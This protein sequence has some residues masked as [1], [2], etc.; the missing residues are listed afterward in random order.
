MRYKRRFWTKWADKAFLP[1]SDS[2]QCL[3]KLTWGVTNGKDV[4]DQS[5]RSSPERTL[6][7]TYTIFFLLFTF[8]TR[9]SNTITT[10]KYNTETTV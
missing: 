4:L 5:S 9:H 10:N 2:L 8:Q 6:A 7:C 1:K 3:A